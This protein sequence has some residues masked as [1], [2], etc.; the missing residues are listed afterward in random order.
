MKH[1]G[2]LNLPYSNMEIKGELQFYRVTDFSFTLS[3][4]FRHSPAYTSVFSL[5]NPLYLALFHILLCPDSSPPSSPP[6]FLP[7]YLNG[8]TETAHLRVME[9]WQ[10]DPSALSSGRAA[11]PGLCDAY[12][13]KH[14]STPKL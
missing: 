10:A 7:P 4:P 11:V 2:P 5:S 6:S 8:G 12:L 14:T 1:P 3:S 9:L 13:P